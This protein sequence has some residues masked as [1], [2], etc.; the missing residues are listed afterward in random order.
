MYNEAIINYAVNS[1]V[2]TRGSCEGPS[3]RE[4]P[5]HAKMYLYTCTCTCTCT[6]KLRSVSSTKAADLLLHVYNA[7]KMH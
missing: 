4:G 1:K 3:P 7:N 6:F 2:P 5:D